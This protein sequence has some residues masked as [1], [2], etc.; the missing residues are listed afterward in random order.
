MSEALIFPEGS[1][2]GQKVKFII[3]RPE[4]KKIYIIPA[5]EVEISQ[6]KYSDTG[7]SSG[8][9]KNLFAKLESLMNPD[10]WNIEIYAQ[11][12]IQ[13][14]LELIW[15]ELAKKLPDKISFLS[16]WLKR[17]RPH[18]V[19]NGKLI[20]EGE[21]QLACKKLDCRRLRSYLNSKM[22]NFFSGDSFDI[23]F[24]NGD[25]ASKLKNNKKN[26]KNRENSEE[27]C[28]KDPPAPGKSVSS[29]VFS[30]ERNDSNH[31]SAVVAGSKVSSQRE[32]VSL[33]D[34][35]EN[36]NV[37]IC[38][39]VFAVDSKN[40]RSGK[41]HL[42]SLT[43]FNSSL[44]VKLFVG[45]GEDV[46]PFPETG[47]R[48]KA[49]GEL[50]YDRY[51]RETVLMAEDINLLPPEFRSDEADE[52]RVELHMHTKMSQM[53]SV[54]E[55]EKAV[56]RAAKWG[57]DALAITDHGIV[58][59]FPDAYEAARK[60]EIKL[61]MGMEAYLVDDGEK[62]V[63]NPG[64]TGFDEASYIV[65]DV[66]TTGLE[67]SRDRII[68]LGAV[69]IS[70]D[71]VVDDFSC[72]VNPGQ[73][74]SPRI[75]NL[76]GIT[77]ED[78]AGAPPIEDVIDDF[79]NFCRDGILVAH[80]AEFDYS[81]LR[82]ECLR[83]G[84]RV[85]RQ[86]LLDT[87]ALS[88][89]LMPGMNSHSLDSL[90]KELGV[91]L[92]EHHRARE[93]AAA[94]SRVLLKLLKRA[95]SER[96]MDLLRELNQFTDNID[97][98]KQNYY[99]A[100]LLARN[101]A[102]LKDLYYLVSRSHIH[103]FYQKP[104][105]LKSELEQFRD[106]ILVGS[107]CEA[108]EVFQA[109]SSQEEEE[110]IKE[111]AEFYDYLEIQPPSNNKF[112]IPDRVES[113]E[114]LKEINR[115]I[116][117]LGEELD[118]PVVATGDA[119]YLDPED[120]IY[121]AILQ[122]GQDYDDADKQPPIYFK[123]TE[124]MLEAC[125]Y[126]GE[127]KSREIVIENPQK[128]S[129][130]IE[131]I[132]PMPEELYTPEIK[133]ADEKIRSKAFQRAQN[134]Y[135][136][137]LPELV[138]ERL[139]KELSSIIDN[140]FAVIYLISHRL[141]KK[142]LSEGYLV[143][144]RGSVGSSLVA[145]MTEITEVNPLPP[146]YRCPECK[147]HKFFPE[148]EDISGVDLKEKDCP[149]CGTPLKTDG[150]SIPFAVFMGFDGSKV[151]DIDLNFSGEYQSK[152]HE[153]T[154]NIF[155]E[156]YVFRAGT[157]STIANRTAYGF[158]KGYLQDRN[159]EKRSTE[160]NRLVKGCTGV[161]RTTGQHPGG[162]MVVPRNMD[163]HDFTPI[164]RPANDKE[165][166]VKTTHFDYHAISGRM[167][168]LDLLGHDDPT[169]IRM[170]QDMTGVNPLKIDL[171][172]EKTMSIFSGVKALKLQENPLDLE[173]GT[174]GV[175]EF[176]TSFVRQMLAETRPETFAEL[177]R[178]SGLS[179][180]SDVWLNNARQLIKK[181]IAELKDVISVRDDIMNYLIQEGVE[182]K[183]AFEI[184]EDVR[185]GKGLSNEQERVMR[186]NGVP[187]W[188][189]ESCQ[190]IKYMFPKAHAAA[191]V[192]MAYRIAYFK[193][194]YP[195]K[196]YSTYFTN[197]ASSYEAGIVNRGYDSILNYLNNLKEKGN[198]R[199]PKENNMI[200]LLQVVIE[201]MNRGVSFE[202][203]DLYRSCAFR[204]ELDEYK[205]IPPLIGVQGLGSTAAENIV[206][207]REQGEF[208]SIEDF[209]ERT[210]VSTTVVE[211]LRENNAFKDLPEK[212]QLSL[213]E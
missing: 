177:V 75:K 113:M 97:W 95:K 165:A 150:F 195:A 96:E 3:V 15:P 157:I 87:L 82:Q 24:K 1:D 68:E 147:W 183:N 33:D 208:M 5:T 121:R 2:I 11:L 137:P 115:Q 61:I 38:G 139:E 73:Q 91:T 196:F 179:H 54:I 34:L 125:S 78:L 107:A 80:N 30:R 21:S 104:R 13:E 138:R 190:K 175:P 213:F 118:R 211:A 172:D 194:Y 199:T 149:D 67:S 4:A 185:K 35:P 133:D 160:I 197:N 18:Y 29:S 44:Q 62:I 77:N 12:S 136:E 105:I 151:P 132:K 191:Y 158:V 187:D 16:S 143:G 131:E 100:V 47:D 10:K 36:G 117:Q 114:R 53:D 144:S 156:D 79:L 184:M 167:L 182:A 210:G 123:T 192:M 37:V 28:E 31:K 41:L 8:E 57:H 48:I 111:K 200:S 43:D 161:K 124:E 162:L 59:A 209:V 119:H 84:C 32:V 52:K 129:S 134:L 202:S 170:L 135:G 55:A 26:N 66:E 110:Q 51:S 22:A 212:N 164:Q 154:E 166:E 94:T 148:E 173:V 88:R 108:G 27:N 153:E 72:L 169:S 207:A 101:K 64:N 140:G 7:S 203:V 181:G 65:F 103:N 93:D 58:Q 45:E 17:A 120:S 186:N 83:T 23:E 76:T 145:F 81:F 178:I 174:L 204:F 206:R 163:I 130:M 89:A 127:E 141:V 188:Y 9:L 168:K 46:S 50:Q 146:H 102:G 14:E 106:N 152:I 189:I 198:D 42:F 159:I 69:K 20:I 98:K 25:F 112:L 86:P 60:E 122:A 71:K 74:I 56:E 176:G 99:H 40:T 116:Y 85:P 201:A 193:V 109:V 6:E 39:E 205:L 180:G 90:C 171:S 92:E 49:A 126:L 128:I 70:E 142:S 63:L 19:K 155:G